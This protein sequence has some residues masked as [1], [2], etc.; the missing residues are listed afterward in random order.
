MIDVNNR[1]IYVHTNTPSG[2]Y[3]RD[4]REPGDALTLL[5]APHLA[6]TVDDL[7]LPGV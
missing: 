6:L 2:I 1:V 3:Q 5:N 4:T 7:L